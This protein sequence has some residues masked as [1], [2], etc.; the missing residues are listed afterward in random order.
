[1]QR[2]VYP[3]LVFFPAEKKKSLLYE[4]DMAVIDVLKFVAQHGSNFNHLMREKGKHSCEDI[5]IFMSV[6]LE[7]I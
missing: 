2:E 7:S 6:L 1:M 4:G 3:S 5:L